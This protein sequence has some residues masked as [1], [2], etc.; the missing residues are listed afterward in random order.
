MGC[1]CLYPK[2]E[3]FTSKL[4]AKNS[5]GRQSD[6]TRSRKSGENHQLKIYEEGD[7]IVIKTFIEEKNY[8]YVIS[9]QSWLNIFDCLKYNELKECGR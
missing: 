2:M 4:I 8:L 9:P 1:V 3:N 7:K 6:A 5:K